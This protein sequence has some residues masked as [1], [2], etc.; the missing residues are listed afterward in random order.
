M[1]CSIKRCTADADNFAEFYFCP[2]H[3][4]ALRRAFYNIPKEPEA[5]PP[6]TLGSLLGSLANGDVP[7]PDVIRAFVDNTLKARAARVQ[8]RQQQAEA[9]PR[10]ARTP[11]QTALMVL[12]FDPHKAVPDAETLKARFRN[13]AK[14]YHPDRPAGDAKK[15]QAINKAYEILT[16]P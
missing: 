7:Q 10:P 15:M 8:A 14:T 6:P 3:T 16:Q 12:G 11:R 2:E 5:A 9:P 13:L 1:K 4:Q